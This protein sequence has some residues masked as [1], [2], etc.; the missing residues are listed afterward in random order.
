MILYNVCNKYH[1]PYTCMRVWCTIV[2]IYMYVGIVFILGY[3]FCLCAKFSVPNKHSARSFLTDL[4]KYVVG[5][6]F[7]IS[8]WCE[9][10]IGKRSCHIL[11][12]LAWIHVQYIHYFFQKEQQ[13]RPIFLWLLYSIMLHLPTLRFHC[14][15]CDW[16]QDCC[17]V[18]IN[19]RSCI[20][21][22]KY[23]STQGCPVSS[24]F[25]TP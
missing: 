1:I 14:V 3:M 20:P 6:N 12:T 13:V 23:L 5:H 17:G 22:G 8:L 2:P 11:E 21:L 4:W 24:T 18:R 25:R 16:T 10:C 9:A 15:C 19:S 7:H